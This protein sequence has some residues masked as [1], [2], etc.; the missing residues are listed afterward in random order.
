MI[1]YVKGIVDYGIKFNQVQSF[2]FHGFSYSDWVGCVDNMRSTSG[3]CFSFGFGVFSW[4]S[5]K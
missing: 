4:S 2:N 5:K 3:Y 1:R